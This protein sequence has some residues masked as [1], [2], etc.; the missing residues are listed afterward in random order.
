MNPPDNDLMAFVKDFIWAPLLGLVAWAWSRNEKEHDRLRSAIEKQ[1]E[2]VST[3][4]STL[5]DRIMEHIDD[6]VRDTRAFVVAEDAKLMAE[7]GV[8]RGHI[9]K[10]F[11]KLEQHG[12][13][14]EDRHSE[15][16]A[17]IHS[18]ATTMHQ[19]LAQKADK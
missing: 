5:N 18:L 15:T 14:S 12:L 3:G 11:D 8:Q 2:Q 10:L 4:S 13:R 9:G 17:A 19:A 6:Q 7:L 1:R 16:M